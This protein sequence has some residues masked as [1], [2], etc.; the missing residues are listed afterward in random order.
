MK[1]SFNSDLEIEFSIENDAL[2]TTL[3]Q[4]GK[5]AARVFIEKEELAKAFKNTFFPMGET[6][7]TK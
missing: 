6:Y 5:P 7:G 4:L 3:S 2:Y 1:Y